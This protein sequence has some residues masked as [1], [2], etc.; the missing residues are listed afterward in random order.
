MTSK[1]ISTVATCDK[2]VGGAAQHRTLNARKAPK[3][4]RRP[5]VWMLRAQRLMRFNANDSAS[6]ERVA[7]CRVGNRT[8]R[9]DFS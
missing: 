9:N 7:V 5:V 2:A 8:R 1:V 4:E 3:T 6:G